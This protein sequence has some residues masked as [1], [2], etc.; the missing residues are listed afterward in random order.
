MRWASALC[1]PLESR[2]LILQPCLGKLPV[3][4]YGAQR[5]FHYPRDFGCVK[6]TEKAQLN[7][8]GM[9]GVTCREFGQR[10]VYVVN[11][12]VESRDARHGRQCPSAVSFGGVSHAG[13]I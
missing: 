11:I 10:P 12:R 2:E 4:L 8:L 13:M 7:H 5:Q 6:S 1:G 9:S 3:S